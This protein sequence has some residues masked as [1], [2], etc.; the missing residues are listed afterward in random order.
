MLI[1]L[2]TITYRQKIKKYWEKIA[3]CYD[4]LCYQKDW[5]PVVECCNTL[6]S[7]NVS[8]QI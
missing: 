4:K 3:M 6:K 2:M 7:T 5:G 8:I 1:V